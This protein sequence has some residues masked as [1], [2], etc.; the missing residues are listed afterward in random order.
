VAD[1]VLQEQQTQ[2]NI[3]IFND[4]LNSS[5]FQW[6][7]AGKPPLYIDLLNAYPASLLQKY[8]SIIHADTKGLKQ[9]Q[10]LKVDLVAFGPYTKTNRQ[11]PLA[12]YLDNSKEWKRIYHGDDGSVWKLQSQDN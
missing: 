4:Y 12:R 8:F 7:F 2:P 5:Y 10:E 6:R 11:Y 1:V 3:R 9:F